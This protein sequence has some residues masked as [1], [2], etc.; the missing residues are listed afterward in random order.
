MGDPGNEGH[1]G[2]GYCTFLHG[3]HR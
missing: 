1:T 3:P 2:H